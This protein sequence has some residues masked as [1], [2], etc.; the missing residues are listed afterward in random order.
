MND[1]IER[2]SLGEDYMLCDYEYFKRF[3]IF[4][5]VCFGLVCVVIRCMYLLW[6]KEIEII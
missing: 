1:V 3:F 2:L 6:F 5:N 4:G